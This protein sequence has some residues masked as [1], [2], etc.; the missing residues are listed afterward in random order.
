MKCGDMDMDCKPESR[1]GGGI[2]GTDI[3]LGLGSNVGNTEDTLL[4]ALNLIKSAATV[5]GSPITGA[6]VSGISSAYLSSPV[7]NADQPYFLNCAVM[8]EMPGD[9]QDYPAFCLKLLFFLKNIEKNMGRK[10][11]SKRYMPRVIDIDI[12]FVYYGSLKNFITLDLPKLKLP[13]PEIFNRR[14][15]LEPILD[16]S[17]MYCGLK[18]PFD[19]ESIK[20][21]LAILENSYAGASQTIS[22]YGKFDEKLTQIRR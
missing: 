13:H 8:L 1:G 16:I 5:P 20:K 12:L 6:V 3:C 10:S 21:A 17:D 18:K 2:P 4:K 19:K 14:F 7:G 22:Y 15:V 11:E 9:T